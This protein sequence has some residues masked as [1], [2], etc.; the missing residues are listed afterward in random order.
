MAKEGNPA[1]P[2]KGV[3][4]NEH[5]CRAEECSKK[6]DRAGFCGEHYT[7]FKW[8]LITLEGYKARD[9]DKKYQDFLR[10]KTA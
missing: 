6:P 3:D 9:F 7:W 4:A 1:K 5:K 10:S 2:A 8:G